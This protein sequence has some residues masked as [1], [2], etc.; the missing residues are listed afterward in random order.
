MR[1]WYLTGWPWLGLLAAA[2][3]ISPVL[4]W[5]A[6]HGW[7]SL[8]MQTM[9]DGLDV[10]PAES[11]LGYLASLVLMGSPPILLLAG[12]ALLRGPYRV[13]LWLAVLPFAIFLGVFSLSDEV[14]MH[15]V[16]PITYCMALGAG[17]AMAG[18]PLRRLKLGLAGLALLV[19]LGIS[20]TYYLLL[21]L[22]LDVVARLPDPGKPFRGWPEA[23]QAVEQLRQERGATYI[24]ADRYFHPGYLKLALGVDAAV[25]N[26]NNPGYDAEYGRWRR[27]NGFPSA[28]PEMADDSAIFIG[29]EAVARRYYGRVTPLA[30]V[31]RPNGSS[32][33]PTVPVA[34]VSDPRPET[35]PL[36]NGWQAP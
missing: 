30:P 3:V 27:W 18:A 22:P 9:R 35:M 28:T 8:V 34:L 26:V 19:G 6:A 12:L 36:F 10:T 20:S 14:G 2:L 15:W 17:L 1:R 23:A 11:F 33:P 13:L 16:A 21:S 4:L 5:N 32:R 29:P 24:V 31:M 7:P 25:F